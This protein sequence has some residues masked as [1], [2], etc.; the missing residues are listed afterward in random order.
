VAIL[1]Q[2]GKDSPNPDLLCGAAQLR[3]QDQPISEVGCPR[4]IG[5]VLN[6]QGP[7]RQFIVSA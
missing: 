1:I 7:Q 3:D 6:N 4:A 5:R 2:K